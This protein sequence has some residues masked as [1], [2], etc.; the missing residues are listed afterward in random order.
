MT[1][2]LAVIAPQVKAPFVVFVLLVYIPRTP[3]ES[4]PIAISGS[5]VGSLDGE[6]PMTLPDVVV[7]C[8][9]LQQWYET[10]GTDICLKTTLWL[11]PVITSNDENA[12]VP[13]DAVVAVNVPLAVIAPENVATPAF[14][15][16]SH[17]VIVELPF[18]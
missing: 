7:Y 8:V 3:D 14:V 5:V 16:V 17:G 10:D 15:N 4:L 11:L 6:N 2:P 9:V 18:V 1:A 12:I 13:A